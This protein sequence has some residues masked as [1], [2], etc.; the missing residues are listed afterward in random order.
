[1]MNKTMRNSNIEL[2]RII[3]VFVIVLSHIVGGVKL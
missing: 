2:V 3:S 1:M